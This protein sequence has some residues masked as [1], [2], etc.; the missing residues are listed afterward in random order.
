M[1]TAALDTA[2]EIERQAALDAFAILDTPPEE[3]FDRITQLV[4]L[5]LDV[6]LAMINF[7]DEDRQWSKSCALGP[8]DLEKSDI[9]ELPGEDAFCHHTVE[10][11]ETFVI[12]DAS[13]DERF[14]D[15]PLVTEQPGI[16]FYAGAPLRTPEGVVIGAL[17]A[18][19]FEPRT[20]SATEREQLSHLAEI[21]VDELELRRNQRTTLAERDEMIERQV[22]ALESAPDGIAILDENERYIY[23][24]EAHV[25]LF[26]YDSAEELIG[27]T[28]R[29]LYAD[30]VVETFEQEYLPQLEERGWWKGEVTAQRADDTVFDEAVALTH[31]PEG[32]LVCVCRDVTDQKRRERQLVEAKEDAQRANRLK[33]AF[34]MNMS[35]EIRTPLTSILGYA[36]L[37]EKEA[38]TEDLPHLKTIRTSSQRLLSTLNSVLD[39]AQLE[40]GTMSLAPTEFDLVEEAEEIVEEMNIQAEQKGLDLRLATNTPTIPVELD[41]GLVDRV[42][43]NLI[44]NA[45]K[46]T[47]RGSVTLTLRADREHVEIQVE[48]TGIGI[49]ENQM[50]EIFDAF[51]QQDAGQGRQFEGA[52]IGLSITRNLVEAAGGSIEVE[53]ESGVGSRFRVRLPRFADVEKQD[54]RTAMADRHDWGLNLLADDQK[55][56]VVEDDEATRALLRD[57]LPDSYR[58]DLASTVDEALT[59]ADD[60]RYDFLLID[61]NLGDRLDGIELMKEL[62]TWDGYEDTL[63]VAVTAYAMPGDGEDFLEKGFDGYVAKPFSSED[64]LEGLLQV[65]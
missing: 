56:L 28:W 35:H 33:S 62:R 1:T 63:M 49:E 27:E 17:C 2:T 55:L 22:R 4:R 46:F 14:A 29:K 31:L 47:P 60:R 7:L 5:S 40:S 25:R 20:L 37:L 43:S 24:N 36:E 16:R 48:D 61:I 64:L 15:N 51:H 19:D 30:P 41:A 9:D 52:G 3:A 50:E 59:H 23:V 44:G 18:I 45:I 13:R 58:I 32:G 11:D 12:E 65:G 39:L 53:S 21:V 6:E 38:E 26:G 42:M 10:A 57:M 54:E 34:L 8:V